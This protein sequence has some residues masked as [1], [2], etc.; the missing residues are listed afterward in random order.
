M[1]FRVLGLLDDG[2]AMLREVGA[3]SGGRQ[4]HRL[5]WLTALALLG[6]KPGSTVPQTAG[7]SPE[8]S[9]A[10]DVSAPKGEVPNQIS[11]ATTSPDAIAVRQLATKLPFEIAA[12][13]EGHVLLATADGRAEIRDSAG[14]ITSVLKIPL[15]PVTE[16]RAVPDGWVV[17]GSLSTRDDA[18]EKGAALQVGLDGRIGPTWHAPGL[19]TSVAAS[20]GSLFASDIMGPVYS[21]LSDG[22]L[23][24][25]QVPS[26]VKGRPVRVAFWSGKVAFCTSGELRKE[27]NPYGLCVAD[28]GT[29]VRDIWRVPPIDCGGFLIADAQEDARTTSEW[30]RTIWSDRGMAAPERH[31][32]NSKPV[33][34]GCIDGVLVDLEPPG[35]LQ[36][37]PTLKELRNPLCAPDAVAVIPGRD[38]VWC[39]GR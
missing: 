24:P 30:F 33:G 15:I 23:A 9:A 11:P 10:A 35:R 20:E 39:I 18:E 6:C 38:D 13:S 16:A 27:G 12:V 17:I 14:A 19:F 4:Q 31:P 22:S 32:L 2:M 28:D 25:V 29:T 3:A 8:P 5:F 34:V 21:L 36:E 37:L 1:H 26:N 7:E